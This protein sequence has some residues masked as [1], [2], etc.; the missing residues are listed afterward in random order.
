MSSE[1]DRQQTTFCLALV[2]VILQVGCV[3]LGLTLGAILA[4]LGLDRQLGTLPLFLILL[5]LTSVPLNWYLL[6]RIALSAGA[7]L[8]PPQVEDTEALPI[9]EE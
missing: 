9:K 2:I 4:G 6:R 3:T 7:K 1:D 8:N 5:L